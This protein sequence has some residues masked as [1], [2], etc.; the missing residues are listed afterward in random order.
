[1][2]PSFGSREHSGQM[3]FAGSRESRIRSLAGPDVL[4][5]LVVDTGQLA[6]ADDAPAATGYELVY[7]VLAEHPVVYAPL[8]A[9][10]EGRLL[11]LG[12]EDACVL[13]HVECA[14]VLGLKRS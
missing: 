14:P 8:A 10:V 13:E 4:R 1:M 12:D 11:A 5:Y 2:M 9:I 6:F 7:A 3:T